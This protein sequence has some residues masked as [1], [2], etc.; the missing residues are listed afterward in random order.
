MN[1]H[2]TDSTSAAAFPV[3]KIRAMFPALQRA[4][5]FIFMDNAAGAQIPQSVLDAVTNHLVAYNVQRGGRYGRSITVDQSVAAARESVALLINAYS[6]SEIC[7]GMNATSFIRLVSLGIGQMLAKDRDGGR[8]EII[9]TDMDHDANIATWLALEPAGARFKWWRMREDGNLHVDDL[10]PLVSERTRLVACTV[11]AHS[12]G[13]IIDVASVARIAHAAG[14]EVFLDCVHYGPHGL[15]DVQAW[16]CDY[17][18]CSGYKN[19]S[20]HMGFLW[21]RFETLKRLPTFREDFIPDEPPYKVEAGTFIYENVSGMDA[22]V[23]YLES[24]G[25]NFLPENNRSRRD[26]IVAGM[27]AIRDYELMLAREM[28]KVLKECGAT[29]Y[30]V[31]DEARINERVPTFCFNIAKLSPQR[32]VEEMA[33]MQIGIRDGHMYAPRLMKRL[34]LSMDSGAIR[35]SLVHYNTVEEVHRFGEALRAIIAKLS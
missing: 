14:A 17:L 21:G 28:M 18:V 32:I 20:P 4:G 5:D 7:F 11:T 16:D 2:Q 12:I 1:K 3:E 29:I 25:R 15:M 9:V 19:F 26:N 8:D 24:V 10:K 22:A 34:N 33:A 13:S 23:R 6:P 35:A 27:S 31:A 30:G